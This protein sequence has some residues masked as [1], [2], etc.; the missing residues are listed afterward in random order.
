LTDL[1]VRVDRLLK[2]DSVGGAQPLLALTQQE[3]P[4]AGKALLTNLRAQLLGGVRDLSDARTRKDAANIDCRFAAALDHQNGVIREVVNCGG[5]LVPEAQRL[6]TALQELGKGVTGDPLKAA[7]E[8]GTYVMHTDPRV[9]LAAVNALGE[10]KSALAADKVRP[11]LLSEDPLVAAAAAGSLAR[12]GDRGSIPQ[13]RALLPKLA[14]VP[15]AGPAVAEALEISRSGSSR[16]TRR[17]GTPPPRRSPNSKGPWW[18]R[19][20]WRPSLAA[21]GRRR[22]PPI[23]GW[24]F[25]PRR[26]TSR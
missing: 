10:L 8:V 24:C 7:Q 4:P 2:G 5:G 1:S 11:H 21:P 13:I 17:F 6:V 9:K 16:R 20:T 23:S 25:A 12:L 26:A 18:W 3:L 19:P 15:E 22:C 14:S